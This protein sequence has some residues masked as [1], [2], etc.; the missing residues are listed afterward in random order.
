MKRLLIKLSL[1]ATVCA[2]LVAVP[3]VHA[4]DP[5]E[6]VCKG[7]QA[8]SSACVSRT[9]QNP[10]LG[11]DGVLTKV[12]K[13]LVIVTA[14]ASVIMMMVGGFRYAISAGDPSNINAAKNT[15]LYAI[16]GLIIAIIA[17]SIVSFVISRL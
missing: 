1:I 8:S 3:L 14:A 13:I 2:S 12:I 11:P 7:P 9:N 4:D 10:V 6:A 15:I 16:V 5:L 17:Q